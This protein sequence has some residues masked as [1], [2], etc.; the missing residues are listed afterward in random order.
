MQSEIKWAE[1]WINDKWNKRTETK[2]I[3]GTKDN[4]KCGM[5]FFTSPKFANAKE[6]LFS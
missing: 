2:I 6:F 3:L 4:K 5:K 1:N